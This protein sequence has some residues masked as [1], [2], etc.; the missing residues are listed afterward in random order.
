MNW[1]R[2]PWCRLGPATFVVEKVKDGAE[3]GLLYTIGESLSG[4]YLRLQ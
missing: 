3:S 2:W 4:T 1:R